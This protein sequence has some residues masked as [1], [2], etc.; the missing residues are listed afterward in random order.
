MI[1]KK[2]NITSSF[3]KIIEQQEIQPREALKIIGFPTGMGK[4]YG[5]SSSSIESLRNRTLSIFVAPRIGILNDFKKDVTN[6]YKEKYN[7]EPKIIHVKSDKELKTIQYYKTHEAHFHQIKKNI[8][9]EFFSAFGNSIYPKIKTAQDLDNLYEKHKHKFGKNGNNPKIIEEVICDAWQAVKTITLGH[10]VWEKNKNDLNFH[11][12]QKTVLFQLEQTFKSMLH[13]F[14]FAYRVANPEETQ[15]NKNA[16]FLISNF[17]S[18]DK[19]IVEDYFGLSFALNDINSKNNNEDYVIIITSQK[20]LRYISR[21][22]VFEGKQLRKKTGNKENGLLFNIY[23]NTFC[24]SQSLIPV[25]YIDE[26][27]E[28]YNTITEFNTKETIL[29]NFLFRLKSFLDYSNISSLTSFVHKTEKKL[30][31][32]S[33]IDLKTLIFDLAICFDIGTI[34]KLYETVSSHN[35]PLSITHKLTNW[36]KEVFTDEIMNFNDEFK[37]FFQNKKINN[38]EQCLF[39]FL[40]YMDGIGAYEKIYK[41]YKVGNTPQEKLEQIHPLLKELWIAI[42]NYKYFLINW[43]EKKHSQKLTPNMFFEYSQRIQEILKNSNYSEIIIENI[44][45]AELSDNSKFMFGNNTLSLI[46]S[47]I[48]YLDL[49]IA[50]DTPS[51]N[52]ALKRDNEHKEQLNEN[53]IQLSFLYGFLTSVLI[54]SVKSF[55]FPNEE[56]QKNNQTEK[57]ETTI[58]DNEFNNRK[59]LKSMKKMFNE[60]TNGDNSI[61]QVPD[62][63]LIFDENYI[64][65]QDKNIINIFTC[66]YEE[67]LKYGKGMNS[68]YIKMN[69]VHLKSSPEEQILGFFSLKQAKEIKKFGSPSIV[70]LMSATI[71]IN[72]YFGNFDFEYI[73]KQMGNNGLSLK[74]TINNSADIEITEEHNNKILKYKDSQLHTNIEVF[75]HGQY[76]KPYIYPFFSAIEEYIKSNEIKDFNIYKDPQQK[77]KRFEFESFIKS[78]EYLHTKD[79]KSL[80]FISQTSKHIKSFL[81]DYAKDNLENLITK[82]SYRKNINDEAKILDNIYIIHKEAFNDDLEPYN[83]KTKQLYMK[84]TKALNKDIIIIFYDSNFDNNQKNNLS[85]IKKTNN[86]NVYEEDENENENE[87]EEIIE[88]EELNELQKISEQLTELKEHI[89]NENKYKILLCSTFGSVSKGFN[90]VTNTGTKDS[91]GNL[92]E[93]DF[94]VLNIGMDPY[95]DLISNT[96]KNEDDKALAFQRIVTIKEF[97]Y[98][99]DRACDIDEMNRFFYTNKYRILRKEHLAHIA[100]TIIQTIGRIERRKLNPDLCRRQTILI[101]EETYNKMREFYQLYDYERYIK[102][103]PDNINSYRNVFQSNLSANNQQLFKH[104]AQS[105]INHIGN[106]NEFNQYRDEQ[107]LKVKLTEEIVTFLLKVIRYKHKTIADFHYIWDILKGINIYNNLPQYFK[108]LEQV[109]N[110]LYNLVAVHCTDKNKYFNLYN[111][112]QNPQ[113]LSLKEIFFTKFPSDIQVGLSELLVGD[114]YIEYIT[115]EYH[116]NQTMYDLSLMVFQATKNDFANDVLD[117]IPF[118][119]NGEE[120]KETFKRLYTINN[121]TYYPQKKIAFEFI[122]TAIAEETTKNIFIKNRI[123]FTDTINGDDKSY[124]LYDLFVPHK[125]SNHSAI[126]VKFWSKSTQ[127]LQSKNILDRDTNKQYVTDLTSVKNRIYLNMFGVIEDGIQSNEIFHKCLFI[128]NQTKGHKQFN[129]YTLNKN[130]IN[131]IQN[132]IKKG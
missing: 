77:Y 87:S 130:F 3:L 1:D 124:E 44:D 119:S 78:I 97:N 9:K 26:A 102:D 46:E 22:F 2:H 6:Q 131:F 73:R 63:D 34:K 43:V 66:D 12:A 110:K 35:I 129:K 94:D 82:F 103:L 123:N 76:E 109:Q 80:F 114:E 15:F 64:Y 69:N 89:F 105:R 122:K 23:I 86:Q 50:E 47:Q 70:Y 25:Y 51:D 7:K 115:D 84:D 11:E 42:K 57:N 27:D 59:Y 28:F 32:K 58:L 117:Y 101:N 14:E 55:I 128:K 113:R 99:H 121:E 125:K 21:F 36:E 16:Q 106:E 79:D 8:E 72:S 24:K 61:F 53:D 67:N 33:T 40:C 85:S 39:L 13:I 104:I 62:S 5:A 74:T 60:I 4:T 100:R 19:S 30:G 20:I 111:W 132:E 127:A 75:K 68:S 118:L 95:F 96:S 10:A 107:I 65:E 31:A 92:I 54:S 112:Y 37:N 116:T 91:N 29:D 93:K 126:D 108:E 48:K 71:G 98:R 88:D 17:S 38:P 56:N 81:A 120:F 18:I 49:L 45:F 52:I 41:K 83:I 90:F